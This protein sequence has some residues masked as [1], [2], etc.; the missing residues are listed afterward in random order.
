VNL[1]IPVIG[2][3]GLASLVNPHF[4]SAPLAVDEA[5]TAFK[6]SALPEVSPATVCAHHRHE[7]HGHGHEE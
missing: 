2:D 1:G 7:T 5:V 6:A 3:Q 4:G